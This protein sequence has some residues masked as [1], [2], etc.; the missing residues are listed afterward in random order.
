MRKNAVK[1][2]PTS[3]KVPSRPTPGGG[4][5]ADPSTMSFSEGFSYIPQKKFSAAPGKMGPF[6]GGGGG[7]G[8]P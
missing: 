8:V 7:S 2:S 6:G 4:G 5:P 3:E 1:I